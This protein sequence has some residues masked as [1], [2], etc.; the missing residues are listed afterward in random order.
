MC[1]SVITKSV[2]GC[3]R[4]WMEWIKRNVGE[5]KELSIMQG[6]VYICFSEYEDCAR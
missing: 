6:Y 3:Y 1:N 2:V 4:T 5:S